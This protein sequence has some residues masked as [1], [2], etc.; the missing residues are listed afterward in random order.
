[1]KR[2][3][4]I[5]VLM[6]ALLA[7]VWSMA[8]FAHDNTNKPTVGSKLA[9]FKVFTR[10]LLN[11]GAPTPNGVLSFNCTTGSLI[12]GEVGAANGR[13]NISFCKIESAL[14]GSTDPLLVGLRIQGVKV[15][16]ECETLGGEI[17]LSLSTCGSISDT[18]PNKAS[19]KFV[20]AP[21]TQTQLVQLSE[22]LTRRSD[23]AF[24][25][26]AD[27]ILGPINC[28]AGDVTIPDPHPGDAANPVSVTNI[29]SIFSKGTCKIIVKGDPGDIHIINIGFPG[30]GG[31]LVVHGT[32]VKVENGISPLDVF[33]NVVC[34][35]R[36]NCDGFPPPG[37]IVVVGPGPL[38][39]FPRLVFKG[40]N[41]VAAERAL[42]IGRG[43]QYVSSHFWVG[44]HVGISEF[45]E[46]LQPGCACILEFDPT[47]GPVG[48]VITLT[49]VN[50]TAVTVVDFDLSPA[51]LTSEAD[52]PCP[53]ATC[54]IVNS[55]T[56]T[57][58]V[59][60]T[61]APGD[62]QVSAKSKSGTFVT[63]AKFTV[64]P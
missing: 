50:F 12:Q 55:T 26:P 47:S 11:T 39:P 64:T 21:T 56:I 34:S 32:D 59:P 14:D 13:M 41:V 23:P 48:T 38:G 22:F 54:A 27:Q 7:V 45:V 42:R 33:F 9:Q 31:G 60:A 10:G 58:T 18:P 63:S 49:G 51:D 4:L 36:P 1:M 5:N 24:A 44:Q 28:A 53:S 61:L 8:A 43:G 25:G 20:D 17:R 2:K 52:V 19:F 29:P 37:G 35:G 40:G 16:N 62:Y 3:L 30:G 57:V 6:A 46:I 15:P